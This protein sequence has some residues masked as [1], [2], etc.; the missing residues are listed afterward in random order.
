MTGGD[1]ARASRGRDSPAREAGRSGDARRTAGA[2]NLAR[3]AIGAASA[4][5]GVGAGDR[6]AIRGRR[7]GTKAAGRRVLERVQA[8][9]GGGVALFRR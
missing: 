2:V 8:T 3:W 4:P 6:R 9:N 5:P 1:G 7:R